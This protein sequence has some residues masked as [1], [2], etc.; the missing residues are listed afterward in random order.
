VLTGLR[1][2]LDARRAGRTDDPE[3]KWFWDHYETAP[4]EI[5]EFVR[6][7]GV[8][9]E[10]RDIADVGCGDGIMA[11]GL[12]RRVRPRTLV[13]FDINP[14]DP[15]VLLDRARRRRVKHELPDGLEFR[16]SEP[17]R[18]PAE[19]SSFDVVYTWS[20]FEHVRDPVALLREIRRVLRPEG[21]MMLQLWPFYY[22][23]R[24]SRLWD[25]F[26]D[27]FHHLVDSPERVVADARASTVHS[28]ERA[29]YMT[30]EFLSLNRITL[31]ELHRAI[32]AAGLEVRKLE[33]IGEAAHVPSEANRYPLSQ[34]AISGV[35]LLAG[36]ALRA[37][38]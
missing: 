6:P 38:Q 30:K 31:D 33:A 10:G 29:E 21:T 17:E 37:T 12:A 26:P 25:W 13:G 27:T 14:V 15:A 16:L 36:H 3:S 18:L 8:E 11:L 35:K 7:A 4:R 34:L 23:A 32:L 19:D 20:V 28:P 24:G 1:R 22:S 5:E 9:L 2:Q